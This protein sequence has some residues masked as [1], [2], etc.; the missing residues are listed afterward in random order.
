MPWCFWTKGGAV[1]KSLSIELHLTR[2]VLFIECKTKKLRYGAKIG[3]DEDL[4][5]MAGFI[6][7]IYK[8]LTDALNG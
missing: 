6:V 1:S 2:Q 5:K 8:T 4:E 7:Q 3:L